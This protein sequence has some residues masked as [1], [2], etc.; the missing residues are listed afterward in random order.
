[1]RHVRAGSTLGTW[2]VRTEGT[3]PA[4]LGQAEMADGVTV[5]LQ[6]VPRTVG[7]SRSTRNDRDVGSPAESRS[8]AEYQ[9]D[10]YNFDSR[11]K[12][13]GE[14]WGFQPAVPLIGYH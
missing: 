12:F 6:S 10:A 13:K 1:M 11:T 7:H 14:L 2:P 9:D 3:P 8:F 4:L 5:D